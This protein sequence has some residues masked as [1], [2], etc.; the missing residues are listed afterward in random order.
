MTRPEVLALAGHPA[1]FHR[2]DSLANAEIWINGRVTF[3]FHG[4]FL[5]RIGVY[6]ILNYLANDAIRYDS[7]FPESSTGLDEVCIF[8]R[9]TGISYSESQGSGAN[10][11]VITEGGV[12]IVADRDGNIT[13]MI[14]PKVSYP[15]K[16]T[17]RSA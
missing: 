1:E 2:G 3:W 12:Q 5:E 8:M 13:S 7:N 10:L 6:Y 14:V 4:E 16:R 9:N 17:S 11:E 15:A